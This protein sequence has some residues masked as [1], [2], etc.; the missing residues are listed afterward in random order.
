MAT[1]LITWELGA[2]LGHVSPLQPVVDALAQQGHRVVVALRQV[3]HATM[4]FQHPSVRVVQAPYLV[5]RVTRPFKLQFT[6]AHILHNVGFDDARELRART[7]AWEALYEMVAPDV[8][9]FDHS[10]TALLASWQRQVSRLTIGTGFTCPPAC[11]WLP[12]WR[13][14]APCDVE[15][16]HR[17]ESQVTR[18][19]NQLLLDWNRPPL[20]CLSELY[21]RVDDTVLTTFPELDHFQPPRDG[22][23]WGTLPSM[24]GA[25]PRWPEAG[26]KRIFGYLKP[27]P[28]LPEILKGLIRLRLPTIVFVP[29]IPADSC[30]GFSTAMMRVVSEPLDVQRVA[31]EC[32]VAITHGGHGTT[33]EVLLR[34]KPL[35]ILP[36]NL[37]QRLT[38]QNLHRIGAG[39]G[40]SP[41]Q[42]KA[43]LERL[44]T[45]LHHPKFAAGAAQF[46]ARHQSFDATATHERLVNRIAE[47]ATRAAS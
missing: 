18:H 9:V 15:Q 20:A 7:T 1:I 22:E 13:P 35:L 38:A 42:P 26:G 33:V 12:N 28:H 46:A 31:Q 8:I 14:T 24:P 4:V 23:Y 39:L 5:Q 25:P 36:Q 41:Q 10:P 32:D 43:V 45:L 11:Q 17:E 3:S 40:V 19:V 44:S 30:P 47:L 37:E 6:F 29:G 2:G 21:A 34:G 16:L 27:N